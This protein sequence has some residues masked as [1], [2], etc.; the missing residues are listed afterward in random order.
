VHKGVFKSSLW[1]KGIK[2]II[3]ENPIEKEAMEYFHRGERAE[4]LKIQ[5]EFVNALREAIKTQDHCSCKKPCKYHGKCLECV[6]IHRA[7]QEHLP[8][9]F[10]PM[11]N[12]KIEIL[13]QLTEHTMVKNLK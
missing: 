6:A 12:K 13:S 10:Q 5:D 2:M 7:H 3:D 1:Q 8:N 11:V 4:G 9:C